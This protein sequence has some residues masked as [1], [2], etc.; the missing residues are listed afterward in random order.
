MT[1]ITRPSRFARAVALAAAA[2][3]LFTGT[4]R[5]AQADD[6]LT[7][8][9]AAIAPGLY[10]ILEIVAQDAGF[11]KKEHLNFTSQLVNSPSVAAQLVATGRGDICSL[12][13]EAVLQGYDK[14]LKLEYFFA[15]AKRFS[16]VLAVPADSPIQ[17]LA[18]FKGKN[19]G[20]INVG[21][22]GE[23]TAQLMLAG[24]GLKKSDFSFLPIGVGPQA[25]EAIAGK[26][27]DAV[28]FPYGE[29][30]PIEVVGNLK[31]RVFRDPTL[32]DISNA[33]L[34]AAPATVAS[35]SDV[36][37]RFTRAL[38]EAS[39]FVRYNPA[40]SA[41]FFLAAQGKATPEAVARETIELQMLQDDL[42][43]ADPSSKRIGA[44][45][46][47][48]MQVLSRTLHDYGKTV[49]VVPAS[50]VA[51]NEFVAYANDFDHKA[52]IALAKSMK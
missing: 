33:G 21:S 15:H 5:A 41:R 19:I 4:P 14:G 34:A 25:I 38:V 52:V 16:N 3:L 23:V 30:V 12:S 6:T 42:P 22:A 49:S 11:F 17:T 44:F 47:T 40:V 35:K 48:G 37:K 31:M 1:M 36:L 9:N 32:G 45:S 28:A 39:L 13:A 27:V 26:R 18:D 29:I 8:L 7:I 24:A 43:G 46:M 50:A 2:A 51:T 10:G 20:E